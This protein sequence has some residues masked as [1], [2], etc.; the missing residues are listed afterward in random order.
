MAEFE[1]FREEMRRLDDEAAGDEV[2]E[3]SEQEEEA[4]EILLRSAPQMDLSQATIDLLLLGADDAGWDVIGA[5]ER[6]LA[7]VA[8]LMHALRSRTPQPIADMLAA[9]R[10]ERQMPVLAAAGM[11]GVIPQT[12]DRIEGGQTALLRNLEPGRLAT[13]VQRL[14]VDAMRVIDALFPGPERGPVY[15]Y[16]PRASA[17][18][19]AAAQTRGTI[20]SEREDRDWIYTFLKSA[21]VVVD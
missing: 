2:V 11:L 17:E 18:D 13:Y 21:G 15:G 7:R 20:R 9:A 3:L 5:D 8:M 6:G 12:L 10:R 1:R 14:G 4:Q 16:T 19:R